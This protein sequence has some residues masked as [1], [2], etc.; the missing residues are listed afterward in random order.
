MSR[1]PAVFLLPLALL[2]VRSASAGFFRG[3]PL[4]AQVHASRNGVEKIAVGTD[5]LRIP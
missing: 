4:V 1:N 2:A 5:I 3:L